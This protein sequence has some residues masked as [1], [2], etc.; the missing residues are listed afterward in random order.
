MVCLSKEFSHL[1]QVGHTEKFLSF[2]DFY[3]VHHFIM[4]VRVN[5]ISEGAQP[6]WAQISPKNTELK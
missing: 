5:I 3:A 2:Q 4:T 1:R 6:Y